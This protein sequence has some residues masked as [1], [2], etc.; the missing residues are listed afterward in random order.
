MCSWF[1][2]P[3]DAPR[4]APLP[5]LKSGVSWCMAENDR[6]VPPNSEYDAEGPSVTARFLLRK[7]DGSRRERADDEDWSSDSFGGRDDVPA[8]GD[9]GDVA[10]GD[11]AVMPSARSNFVCLASRSRSLSFALAESAL[12]SAVGVAISPTPTVFSHKFP[13]RPFPASV[14]RHL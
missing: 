1:W 10:V 9:S 3:V 7:L 14:G 6:R 12:D 11:C 8:D 13:M 2:K 4:D 5:E